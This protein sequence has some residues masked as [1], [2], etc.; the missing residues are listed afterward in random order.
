VQDGG[1]N[2]AHQIPSAQQVPDSASALYS[3]EHID[4]RSSCCTTRGGMFEA[5]L[6]PGHVREYRHACR[7]RASPGGEGIAGRVELYLIHSWPISILLLGVL[8]RSSE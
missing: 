7:S 8:G 5:Q 6:F 2:L 3:I 1:L 4:T